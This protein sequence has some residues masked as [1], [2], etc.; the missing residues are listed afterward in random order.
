MLHRPT[1]AHKERKVL[2]VELF[3]AHHSSDEVIEVIIRVLLIEDLAQLER[4]QT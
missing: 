1:L 4:G 2:D 3:L